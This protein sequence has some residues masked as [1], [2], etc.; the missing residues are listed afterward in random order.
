LKKIG[1]LVL[2][3]VLV[4][5]T[6]GVAYSMWWDNITVTGTV[7]TGRVCWEF[8]DQTW[9]DGIPPN[10]VYEWPGPI[11]GFPTQASWIAVF[12]DYTTGNGFVGGFS[13]L[14]KNVSWGTCD[15]L[16][17]NGNVAPQ[18]HT[19]RATLHNVYPCNFNDF[20]FYVSNC[21]N[22]PIKVWRVKIFDNNGVLQ[23]TLY[24]NGYVALD[25]NDDT[26]PD[27]EISYKDNFGV[28]IEPGASCQDSPEFS[29]WIHTLQCAPQ[30]ANLT[31]TITIEAVQWNEY[32]AGP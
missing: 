12:G 24:A 1:L 29:L 8:C 26:C 22:I 18:G 28:Q 2:A 23:A 14:D 4:L 16:D 10:G 9:L 31:F 3:L 7:N 6:V 17:D 32:N 21:G 19:I 25:L 11:P 27:I 20:G 15:I 13:R 5:G 30:G